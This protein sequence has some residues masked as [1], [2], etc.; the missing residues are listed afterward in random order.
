MDLSSSAICLSSED[1]PSP[2]YLE[3]KKRKK[4]NKTAGPP[5]VI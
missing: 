1:S 4:K 2:I 5:P 3:K